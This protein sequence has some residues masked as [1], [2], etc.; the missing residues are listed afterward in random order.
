MNELSLNNISSRNR[1]TLL[2]SIIIHALVLNKIQF[3]KTDKY[4]KNKE[5]R[6]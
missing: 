5:Y 4:E 2:I 6:F 3:K 1:I